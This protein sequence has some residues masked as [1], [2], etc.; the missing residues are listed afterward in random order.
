MDQSLDDPPHVDWG[1]PEWLTLVDRLQEV[2]AVQARLE[3]LLR[4][5]AL[6]VGRKIVRAL[7]AADEEERQ[8]R[9]RLPFNP[10]GL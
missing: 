3:P 8:I 6:Q 2:R 10:N 1:S 9:A 5:P 7:D 4:Q